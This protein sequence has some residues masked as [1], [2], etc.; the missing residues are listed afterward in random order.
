LTKEIGAPP[1][2]LPGLSSV[3]SSNRFREGVVRIVMETRNP[4]AQGAQDLGVG[5]GTLGTWVNRGQKAFETAKSG[6][7]SEPFPTS[8]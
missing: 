8:V 4:V 6:G 1:P 3:G 5:E 2:Q 7:L